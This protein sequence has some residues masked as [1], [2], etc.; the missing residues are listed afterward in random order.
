M[1][2]LGSVSVN[3]CDMPMKDKSGLRRLRENPW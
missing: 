3:D 2:W 1:S